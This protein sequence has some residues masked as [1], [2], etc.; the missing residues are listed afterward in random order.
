MALE[1]ALELGDFDTVEVRKRRGRFSRA[2]ATKLL[3]QLLYDVTYEHVEW[4]EANASPEV[5][6]VRRRYSFEK[7]GGGSSSAATAYLEN[8]LKRCGALKRSK[9]TT[10]PDFNYLEMT[11][12]LD[13]KTFTVAG[14]LNRASWWR[15]MPRDFPRLRS[16]AVAVRWWTEQQAKRAARYGKE[17]IPI[18]RLLTKIH[19]E[20]V[21]LAVLHLTTGP[22]R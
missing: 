11:A 3:T 4:F 12:K 9:Q 10:G 13:G 17:L 20:Q 6:S 19:A 22:R 2:E 16:K 8:A 1:D 14:P 18:E 21:R 5:L 7:K 15:D